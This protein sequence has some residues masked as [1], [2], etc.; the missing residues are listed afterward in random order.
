MKKIATVLGEI[1]PDKAGITLPHEHLLWDQSGYAEEVVGL[2][3]KRK[4]SE[5]VT[6]ENR[7]DVVYYPF[8]Y[9]DDL[10]L[11]DIDITIKEALEFKKAG[12]STIV[13]LS[14][15]MFGRDPKAYYELAVM[16]GLNVVFGSANYIEDFWSEEEKK[17]TVMDIKNEIVDEFLNGIG[18]L[19]LKP[20]IIGEI[21]ISDVDNENEINSLKGSALAQ[22]EIGCPLNI[23]P[24]LF[25]KGGKG[26]PAQDGHKIL[27][28]IESCGGNINQVAISHCDLNHENYDY[29]DSIA[30]RGAYIEFDQFGMHLM[31][32]SSFPKNYLPCDLQRVKAI[33]EQIRRGN[34]ERILISHDI[35]F[36]HLLKKWGGHGYSHIIKNIIPMMINYGEF[37]EEEIQMILIEN[38]KRFLS[39]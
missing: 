37:T 5:T 38:P 31:C 24:S 36:K 22:K 33:K 6:L 30:K 20:G 9:S 3:E 26:E 25:K 34:L 15:G 11:S 4:C 16:T 7:G 19:K 13:E 32:F 23:H 21:G 17:R 28:V 35:C 27:D 39:W 1:N 14:P 29:L 18:L 10:V 8:C 2:N 12:G